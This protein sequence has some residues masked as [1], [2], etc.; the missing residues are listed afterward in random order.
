MACKPEAWFFGIQRSESSNLISLALCCDPDAD[1]TPGTFL[2][3]ACDGL[4]LEIE[5]EENVANVQPRGFPFLKSQKAID[6]LVEEHLSRVSLFEVVSD[7]SD[8]N[9][10]KGITWQRE[11]MHD[12]DHLDFDEI[13]Q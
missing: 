8:G 4:V 5:L 1:A 7:E 9:V 13:V 2:K 11:G 10:L 12:G 6:P 3:F